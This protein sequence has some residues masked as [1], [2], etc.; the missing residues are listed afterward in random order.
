MVGVWQPLYK[1]FGVNID[2]AYQTF[3]WGSEAKDKAAV[4]CVIVGFSTNHIRKKTII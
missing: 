3:K 1:R 4:H 2:F